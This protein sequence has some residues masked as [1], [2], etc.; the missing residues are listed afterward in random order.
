MELCILISHV[1]IEMFSLIDY[2]VLTEL[3]GTWMKSGDP[4]SGAYPAM[5]GGFATS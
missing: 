5:T 2:M 4:T 1:Q 3:D